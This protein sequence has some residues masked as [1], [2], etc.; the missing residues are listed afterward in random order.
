MLN[1]DEV[2]GE[3]E[4]K[5]QRD[6]Y[7]WYP[8]VRVKNLVKKFAENKYYNGGAYDKVTERVMR[9]S[10]S[11]AKELLIK[12]LEKNYEVGIKVLREY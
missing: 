12:L 9:M 5:C 6:P 3:L 1:N 11:D 8:N 2:R 4:L 10:D 7:Q